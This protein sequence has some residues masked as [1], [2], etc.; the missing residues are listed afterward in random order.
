MA[1]LIDEARSNSLMSI[2]LKQVYDT[3]TNGGD[4]DSVGPNDFIAF[5][6]IGIVL[7]DDTFDLDRKSVV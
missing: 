4:P 1:K 7:T 3:I 6:P 2:L 5:D